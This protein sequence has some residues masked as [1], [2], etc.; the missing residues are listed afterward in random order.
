MNSVKPI[1]AGNPYHKYLRGNQIGFGSFG[2]VFQAKFNGNVFAIKEIGADVDDLDWVM[3]EVLTIIK[4]E[5]CPNIVKYYEIWFSN[6]ENVNMQVTGKYEVIGN[7]HTGFEIIVYNTARFTPIGIYIVMECC[8][9]TLRDVL[10]NGNLSESQRDEYFKGILSGLKSLADNRVVHRDL[11]PENIFLD[12]NGVIKI[13]DFG[14]AI[15]KDVTGSSHLT[16]GRGTND[17]KPPEYFKVELIKVREITEKH[18]VYS[19]GLI[20]YFM[21]LATVPDTDTMQLIRKYGLCYRKHDKITFRDKELLNQMLAI[22]P[23]KRI[24]ISKLYEYVFN[25]T[26]LT[27][28]K[29]NVQS[30]FVPTAELTLREYGEGDFQ[31]FD[32]LEVLSKGSFNC[33]MTVKNHQRNTESFSLRQVFSVKSLANVTFEYRVLKNLQ[34]INIL[35]Y[36]KECYYNAQ[37]QFNKNVDVPP[38]YLTQ[39]VALSLRSLFGRQGFKDSKKIQKVK[40]M[41]EIA[42]G[43]TYLHRRDIEH[44]NLRPENIFLTQEGIPKIGNFLISDFRNV[45]KLHWFHFYNGDL[46]YIDALMVDD[47]NKVIEDKQLDIYS[48][49]L[50][51]TEFW[52]YDQL[53]LRKVIE[54][55]QYGLL[56]TGAEDSQD[57]K[58]IKQFNQARDDDRREIEGLTSAKL[59]IMFQRMITTVP[60]NRLNCDEL[61]SYFRDKQLLD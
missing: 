21:C 6:K 29:S 17:F 49:G 33:M 1:F 55:L 46:N 27:V 28:S 23:Q 51:F 16:Q 36:E 13:G 18:D 15:D 5:G 58:I 52:F 9:M 42:S 14:F 20:Y 45:P 12:C 31:D 41:Q 30:N 4:L 57:L 43:L 7:K 26:F 50:I 32:V 3:R 8:N 10:S 25:D 22:D 19:C 37:C 53:Y 61:E 24:S 56:N 44:L 54:T 35:Q 2:T 59:R 60:G 38:Y 48:L 47:N 34:H 40:L 39:H 11:K